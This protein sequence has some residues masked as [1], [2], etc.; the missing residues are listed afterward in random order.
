MINVCLSYVHIRWN[1]T[2]IRYWRARS[3]PMVVVELFSKLMRILVCRPDQCLTQKIEEFQ[4]SWPYSN[5]HIICGK[6]G[7]LDGG[8]GFIV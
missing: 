4:N 1:S 6:C 8:I 7:G 5:L 3:D 2:W